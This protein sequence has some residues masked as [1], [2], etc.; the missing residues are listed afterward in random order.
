MK[1]FNDKTKCDGPNGGARDAYDALKTKLTRAAAQADRGEVHDGGEVFGRL[2][3]L[4][5]QYRS[6]AMKR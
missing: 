6:T 3:K 1:K 2:D 4:I 5:M